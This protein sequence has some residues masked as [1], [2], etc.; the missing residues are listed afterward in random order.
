MRRV[1]CFKTNSLD[2]TLVANWE[3]DYV[4][5]WLLVTD[6]PPYTAQACWYAMRSWIECLFKDIKRGGLG[7]HHTKMTDPKRA[8]RLWLAIAVATL[9]LVGV[10]GQTGSNLPASSL[11]LDNP[12]NSPKPL[13]STH[14][15]QSE[16][17]STTFERSNCCHL[18]CFRRGFLMIL[19]SVIQ[20]L[21]LP[22]GN[23]TPQFSLS[24][25]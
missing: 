8:E 2:C 3:S 6:L 7:W 16:I 23:F 21:P 13:A 19:A 25:A 14:R 5:P 1:T 17:S 9:W 22:I 20:Q 24:S 12:I 15:F 4:D 11:S 10:G 18:S